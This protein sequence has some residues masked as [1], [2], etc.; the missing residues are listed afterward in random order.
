MAKSPNMPT[1]GNT[2]KHSSSWLTADTDQDKLEPQTTSNMSSTHSKEM[3]Q[4]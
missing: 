1:N 4:T 2:W 3:I